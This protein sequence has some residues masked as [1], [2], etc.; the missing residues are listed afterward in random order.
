[1]LAVDEE[2]GRRNEGTRE[3]DGGGRARE[4]KRCESR[5][6]RH[7]TQRYTSSILGRQRYPQTPIPIPLS[8]VFAHFV[9]LSLAQSTTRK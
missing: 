3:R 8:M 6:L 7:I 4:R 1:M 2:V 9:F 5:K